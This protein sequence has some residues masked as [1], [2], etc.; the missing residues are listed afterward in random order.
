MVI[1]ILKFTNVPMY[2]ID[3][4]GETVVINNTPLD[5]YGK[6]KI[7]AT[8]Y[9]ADSEM[10]KIKRLPVHSQ[11]RLDTM[12]ARI[13]IKKIFKK[14]YNIEGEDF[15]EIVIFNSEDEDTRGLPR[16][17]YKDKE[18]PDCLSISHYDGRVGVAINPTPCGLDIVKRF[19]L[20]EHL[21]ASFINYAFSEI[22]RHQLLN[23]GTIERLELMTLIWGIK[24]AVSKYLG[25]GLIYGSATVEV[26][27]S[28]NGEFVDLIFH[29]KI[30]KE[31]ISNSLKI[32]YC[33]DEQKSYYQVYIE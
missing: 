7:F 14:R 26:F 28:E 23:K 17:Y 11:I 32:Y 29:S 3:F 24:E 6:F 10:K 4:T 15:R 19:T 30:K 16:I 20:E 31:I 18:Y 8:K 12:W 33:W 2:N 9:F 5:M 22:E 25:C 13:L 1:I 21:D 27:F